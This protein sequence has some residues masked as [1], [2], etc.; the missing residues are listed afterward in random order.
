MNKFFVDIE[1]YSDRY[2]WIYRLID[3]KNN[4]KIIKD[5]D[6]E[7]LQTIINPLTCKVIEILIYE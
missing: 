5:C 2:K 1:S 4:F 3:L 6:N 7:W